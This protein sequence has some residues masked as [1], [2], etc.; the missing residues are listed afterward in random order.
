MRRLP[1]ALFALAAV[2]P[3][4]TPAFAHHSIAMF[5]QS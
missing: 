3:F 5:D 2:T 1:T 4:A